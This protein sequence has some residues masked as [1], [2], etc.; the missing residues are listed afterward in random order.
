MDEEQTHVKAHAVKTNK[1]DLPKKQYNYKA[2]YHNQLLL[3][4]LA[5]I[6]FSPSNE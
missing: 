1:F 5:T 2:T 4:Q 3:T 6:N